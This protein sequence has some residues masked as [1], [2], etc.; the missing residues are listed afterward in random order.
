MADVLWLV[1][2]L[3]TGRCAVSSLAYSGKRRRLYLSEATT[4][5][6]PRPSPFNPPSLTRPPTGPSD[7]VLPPYFAAF[8]RTCLRLS[9]ID[10]QGEPPLSMRQSYS[11]KSFRRGEL[12]KYQN[13]SNGS[14]QTHVRAYLHR[15]KAL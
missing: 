9:P 2:D 5:P 11:T 15:S 1:G 14:I 12:S 3:P 4:L 13:K 10:L 8:E 6:S 7:K